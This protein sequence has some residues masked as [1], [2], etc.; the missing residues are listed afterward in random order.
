MCEAHFCSRKEGGNLA[1]LE[2]SGDI[3]MEADLGTWSVIFANETQDRVDY[4]MPVRSLLYE[5]LEYNRQ[6]QDLKKA[7]KKKHERTEQAAFLSGLLPQDRLKPVV[8]VIFYLGKEWDGA[9]SLR[10]MLA[11][12]EEDGSFRYLNAFLNNYSLNLINIHEIEHSENFRTSLQ[13]IF[14]MIN[15]RKDKKK[16]YQ[17]VQEHRDVLGKMDD[18]ET[19][20]AF[21][22][23]G[24]QKRMEQLLAKTRENAEGGIDMC[25]AIDDLIK[26]GELRG[27]ERGIEKG[28]EKGEGRLISLIAA[29][30]KDNRQN[31]IERIVADSAL[32]EELYQKYCV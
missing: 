23:L 4:A 10:E 15:Y 12:D 28:I 32:R 31:L 22:L 21:V 3:R 9:K 1:A 14:A 16:L 2:R 13:Y 24:E 30:I 8:T 6:I 19:M 17:Y 7:H 18:V 5:A 29:L 27:E 11:I 25:K 26:D 20:A